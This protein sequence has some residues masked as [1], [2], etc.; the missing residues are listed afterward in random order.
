M[1]MK[2]KIKKKTKKKNAESMDRSCKFERVV[3]QKVEGT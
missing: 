2:K 1:I 3:S